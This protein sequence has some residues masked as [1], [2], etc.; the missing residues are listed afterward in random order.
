MTVSLAK[1]MAVELSTRTGV[2]GW[3]WPSSSR[4]VRRG[5]ASLVLWK[6]VPNSASAAEENTIFIMAARWR[7]V[8]FRMSGP[9]LLPRKKCPPWWLRA[10]MAFRYEESL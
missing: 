2:G 7:M 6:R 4:V 5:V 3:G 9:D 1:P 10:P 8:P